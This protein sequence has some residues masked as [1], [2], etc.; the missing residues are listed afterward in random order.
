MKKKVV[1]SACLLGT[2]CRYDGASK[3]HEGVMRLAERYDLIPVCPECLGGLST[4]RVPAEI[5]GGCV[6]TREGTD[7]TE[8]YR[9]GAHATL[10]I[11]EREQ[12][13]FAV[14]KARSPACG[15]GQVYDGSFTGTL[16]PGDGITAAA[17]LAAG[18]SV[19]SEEELAQLS[20]AENVI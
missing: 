7:V 15:R 13:A 9:R 4:P 17:L 18:I 14:L 19:F 6:R 16:R 5:C 1:V 3:P 2:P 12:P 20:P 11:C 8:A 10:A